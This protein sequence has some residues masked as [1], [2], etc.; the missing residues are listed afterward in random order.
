M[1][2]PASRPTQWFPLWVV[3]SVIWG[4]SFLF[5]KV[6]GEFLDPYQTTFGRMGLGALAL[7][8]YLFA[9]GKRPIVRGPAV[10][11]LGFLGLIAQAI[12]FTLFAWAEHSI[13]SIAAGL[14]NSTMSLWTGVL[15]IAIL[16]EERLNK[17]RTIGMVL[18]FLGILVLLGVWATDF[19]GNWLAYLACSLSTIGYAVAALWTRKFVSPMHLDPISAIATQLSLGTLACGVVMAFTSSAPTQWPANGVASIVLLGAL[20]TG[21]ALV[22]NYIII[23]RA[24]AVATS[25]VTYSIPIVSTL[26]GA[27]VLHEKLHWYEPIGAV[28]ILIGIALVQQLLPRPQKVSA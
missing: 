4:F 23:H 11:H 15:A 28:I 18:G 22:L 9:T 7:L 27:L 1:S 5:I 24:G 6:A 12:P 8:I 26:A 19:R 25:T 3:L 13:S 17:P 20:G 10:A 14:V 16:P 21:I 2:Q